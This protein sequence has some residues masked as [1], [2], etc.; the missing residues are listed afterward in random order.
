MLNDKQLVIYVCKNKRKGN[1]LKGTPSKVGD[2]L[3]LMPPD[4]TI[5]L[6]V[7]TINEN[8][9]DFNFS[10]KS[11]TVADETTVSGREFETLMTRFVFI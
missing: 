4:N 1:V 2:L 3:W 11:V 8:L 6:T 5:E 7:R 9:K 10:L